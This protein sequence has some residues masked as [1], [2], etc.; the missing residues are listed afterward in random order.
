MEKKAF[1][2]QLSRKVGEVI[3]SALVLLG[4]DVPDRM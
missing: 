2:V 4:I 3:K 1:R